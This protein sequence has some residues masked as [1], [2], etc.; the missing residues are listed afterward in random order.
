MSK[1]LI[2]EDDA[3]FRQSL[4]DLLE[5]EG[6]GVI[7]ASDGVEGVDIYRDQHADLVIMDI[8][9]PK[10]D[11]VEAIMDLKIDFPDVRIIAISGGGRMGPSTYLALAKSFGADM[12]L[13]KP[14]RMD[15]LLKAI[16]D[17]LG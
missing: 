10:K 5:S 6:Y 1:I 9:M 13:E 14:V 11:G 16:K 4:R 8:I 2:I 17:L 12:I 7:E 3:S 15:E